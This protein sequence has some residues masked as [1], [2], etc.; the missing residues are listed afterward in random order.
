[1]IMMVYSQKLLPLNISAGSVF[2]EN[3]LGK[4]WIVFENFESQ[5]WAFF[6][7]LLLGL[8][9]ITSK[10]VL[11]ITEKTLPFKVNFQCQ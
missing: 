3:N 5:I 11:A 7:N 1:M 4:I 8:L 10:I 2:N 6:D 9:T